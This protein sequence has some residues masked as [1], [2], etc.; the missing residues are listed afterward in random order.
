MS[1]QDIHNSQTP[2]LCRNCEVRHRGLCGVLEPEQ[3]L[4]LSRHTRVV[5]QGAG[6]ELIADDTDVTSYANVMTG[7]VKLT[8]MLEDG[9]QQVVGLQFAPD[10]LGRL[11][12]KQSR[13][14][15]EAASDVDLCRIPKS[16][17]EAIMAANP[18][19]EHRLHEQTLRELDEARDWMV[20]LGRKTAGEK[21]A[22]F[23]FLIATHID[24]VAQIQRELGERGDAEFDLPLSRAD[25]ADFLGLTIETVSRQI[26]KLRK[27][28]VIAVENNRKFIIPD[29][30]RLEAHCG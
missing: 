22:S 3:L 15:A 18:A 30:G 16:A 25:I 9:R 17:L 24:P 10:F 5:R 1:R 28:G 7:V 27:A 12:G 13:L 14:S 29:L 6:S 23:L 26:T 2:V 11:Y 21:V 8:K 4:E 19:L 20:T